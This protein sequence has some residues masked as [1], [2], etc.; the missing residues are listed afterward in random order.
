MFPGPM[1]AERLTS[2]ASSARWILRRRPDAWLLPL[3]CL[4]YL[5]ITCAYSRWVPA[6]EANDEMDHVVNIE[7]ILEHRELVPLRLGTWHETHQPPLYYIAAAVWQSALGI[8]PFTPAEPA[9]LGLPKVGV[10]PQLTYTHAYT[11]PQKKMAKAV[12]QLRHL[13]VIFG[14][15]TVA[16]TYAAGWLTTRRRD[17][18]LGAAAFVAFLPKFTVISAAVTNDS[19]VVALCSCALVLALWLR[20]AP[21]GERR[22]ELIGALAL[23]VVCGAALLTKLN[24]LPVSSA[25]LGSLFFL[26]NRDLR[27]RLAAALAAFAGTVLTSG[28]W[29]FSNI[30][31]G[32]GLLGQREAFA[33]L[34]ER[35]PGLITAV[36]WTDRERFLN[37]VPSQL[38]HTVWYNG[39]WN[40]FVAPFG[41]YL[42]LWLLLG[43]SLFA[44]ARAFLDGGSCVRRHDPGVI[45]L[46]VCSAMALAA[47][48]IIAKSTTQAE[49]RVGFV[50]LSSA[51]VLAVAGLIEA[52]GGGARRRKII[53]CVWPAALFL[54]NAYVFCRFVWPFR[55]L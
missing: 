13:S 23:G 44:M 39:A 20:Q 3:V 31:R 10:N 36:P 5:V 55:A 32:V 28:W 48:L 9:Q 40:Q 8:P 25:V 52:A 22:R 4:A 50:G 54:F 15:A 41:F 43:A 47:I 46:A 18:A 35:L 49:G 45:L 37:F 29:I 19:L 12:H 33:W 2:G 26:P 17:I 1:R 38:L 42:V 7:H 24:S 14:L 21:A 27:A 16:L 34:D 11:K 30:E 51:A 53:V 6:W